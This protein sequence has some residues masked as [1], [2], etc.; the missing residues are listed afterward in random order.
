MDEQL[1]SERFDL[2]R[3]LR[4]LRRRW[5]VILL[6]FLLVAGSAAAFSLA[7]QKEYTA[8]ASLLFR[9]STLGQDIL[10][11]GGGSSSTDPTREA[12]TNVKLVQ[13]P[14]VAVL[15][16]RAVGRVNPTDV[17][18][19]I[20]VAAEGQSNV[21]SIKATDPDPNFAARL[22]NTYARQFIVF[23]READKAKIIQVRDSVQRQL[24]ALPATEKNSPAGRS[25]QTRIEQ[26]TTLASL[27]TGNAELIQA[28]RP[29]SSPSSPNTKLNVIVGGLLG[30]LIGVGVALLLERLNRRLREAE[31]LSSMYGLPILCEVPESSSLGDEGGDGALEESDREAFRMLR[32]RLRY[33]NVDDEIRSVLITS[34]NAQ[35]GKSTVAWNLAASMALG[36][37][38]KVVLVEAD[39]RRPSLALKHK[40]VP[41]PGLAD[42][43][44]ENLPFT[45]V[46]QQVPLEPETNGA[47]ATSLDVIVAGA[48]PPNP[49]ELME[50][51]RMAELLRSLTTM[52]D[53]VLLDTAPTLLVADPI[54]L[55]KQVGGVIVVS[56]LGRTT[57]D[58]ASRLRDQLRDL[59]APVLGVV[60][61]RV[62]TPEGLRY[63]YGYGY[64]PQA[65]ASETGAAKS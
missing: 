52:Y 17:S 10:G 26:L 44:A 19:A 59:N 21:V 22:A 25:L 16:A 12:A 60:A 63:G 48:I 14:A 7:Q 36:G 46:V 45:E 31:E 37:R 24:D 32:A 61:N 55:I 30:L 40:L 23:R 57:R 9:D 33:F 5:W 41:T 58:A 27:Q 28:A 3:W 42:A 2:E 43:L 20:S 11:T 53:F 50:S 13:S 34:C 8:G 4:M 29:P 47:R 56:R 1:T 6:C 49:S 35:E 15:A 39:L 18:S 51:H 54:P 65:G 38:E 64:E 62:K